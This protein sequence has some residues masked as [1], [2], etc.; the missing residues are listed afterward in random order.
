MAST[1]TGGGH[2][3]IREEPEIGTCQCQAEGEVAQGAH[4][5][6]WTAEGSEAGWPHEAC[7]APLTRLT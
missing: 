5:Q 2:G 3:Q 7:G 1:I 6:A 4:A